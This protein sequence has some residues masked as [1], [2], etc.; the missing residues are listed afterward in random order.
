MNASWLNYSNFPFFSHSKNQRILT[1]TIQQE[2]RKYSE[3]KEIE[4]FTQMVKLMYTNTKITILKCFT[5]M[6]DKL[7]PSL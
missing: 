2:N 6:L 7:R 5:Q 3:N 4:E 1:E